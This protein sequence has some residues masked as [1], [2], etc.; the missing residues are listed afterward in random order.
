M[1]NGQT[2]AVNSHCGH[3]QCGMEP[4][5]REAKVNY[6]VELK[7]QHQQVGNYLLSVMGRDTAS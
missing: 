4:D 5:G 3:V 6:S 7:L 1:L 2:A